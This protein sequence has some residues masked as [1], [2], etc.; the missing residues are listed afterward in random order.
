[1]QNEKST[2]KQP[3]VAYLAKELSRKKSWIW[4]L[5]HVL[6]QGLSNSG[7]RARFGVQ[8]SPSLLWHAEGLHVPRFGWHD[9]LGI[10]AD[11]WVQ[12]PLDVPWNLMPLDQDNVMLWLVESSQS[13]DVNSHGALELKVQVVP[14]IKFLVQIGCDF[15]CCLYNLLTEFLTSTRF[16]TVAGASS[17]HLW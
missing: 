17:A 6:I 3:K 12:C 5:S 8:G 4:T 10:S 9:M 15:E 1:M 14:G 13:A 2:F 11:I 7:W 16:T